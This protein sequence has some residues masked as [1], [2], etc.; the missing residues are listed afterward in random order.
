M[1]GK[2]TAVGDYVEIEFAAPDA[3][4]RTLVLHATQAPDYA[5]LQFHVNGQN[6]ARIFDGC[7]PK[8]RPAAPVILGLSEPRDRKFKLRLEVAGTNPAAIGAKYY[9]GLDC[10]IMEK[11]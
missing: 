7:A 1:L 3:E 2:T 8:V 4:P 6:V 5:M 9:F 10:L 11:P